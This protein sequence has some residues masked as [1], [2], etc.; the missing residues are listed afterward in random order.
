MF[1]HH[2]AGSRRLHH[3]LPGEVGRI[4]LPSL[5]AGTVLAHQPTGDPASIGTAPPAAPTGPPATPGQPPVA[6]TPEQQA[7]VDHLVEGRLA[8]DR[9]ARPA[10]PPNLAELQ[11]QARQFQALQA[12][13]Q[14]DQQRAAAEALAQGTS[15][16]RQE[17]LPLL[18]A[19]E[20]RAAS[21][22]RLTAEQAA[23]IVAPLNPA[24][25]QAADGTVDAAKVSAY[26]ATLPAGPAV[27]GTVPGQPGPLPTV[28]QAAGG[29]LPPLGQGPSSTPPAVPGAA[30]NAEA[31]RRFGK[32]PTRST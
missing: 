3:D 6:F 32:P 9:A 20:I 2:G 18:V 30:G 28:T 12:S 23:G 19:A 29:F 16:G 24:Y 14:T 25:F 8:R 15:K 17:L 21:A 5:W 10:A 13:A 22:G 27:G 4:A 11:E 1:R 7:Y 26:V 31:D